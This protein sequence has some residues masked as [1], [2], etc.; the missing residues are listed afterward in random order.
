MKPDN[1]LEI[2]VALFI[3]QKSGHHLNGLSVDSF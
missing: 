1:L 3:P 2:I